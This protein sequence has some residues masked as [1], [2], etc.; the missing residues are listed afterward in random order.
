MPL[1][2]VPV[3]PSVRQLMLGLYGYLLPLMLYAL[4]STLALWDLARRT[5]LKPMAVWGWALM[6]FLVPF[7]GPVAY[8]FVGG[9]KLSRSLRAVT[10]GYAHTVGNKGS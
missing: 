7:V 10:V 3:P 8:L 9:C 1:S 2:P 5:D 6:V 4:W